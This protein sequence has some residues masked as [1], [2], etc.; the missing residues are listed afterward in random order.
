MDKKNVPQDALRFAIPLLA[1]ESQEGGRK[2]KLRGVAYS[3]EPITGHS[4]WGTVAFDLSST[5]APNRLPVLIEHDRAQRA[6]FAAAEIGGQITIDGE[7]LDN[8]YGRSVAEEADAGF[9]WQLSV[10]IEPGEIAEVKAGATAKVNGHAV[11]GPAFIFRNSLIREVSLTPTG[12]DHRTTAAVFSS[13]AVTTDEDPTEENNV[14]EHEQRIS[15]LESQIQGLQASVTAITGERD[16]AIAERDAAVAE[17]D[18]AT[19]SLATFSA[20]QRTAEV[21]ALFSDLGLEFGDESAAPY[22]AMDAEQFGTVAQHMRAGRGAPP[23]QLFTH[24]ADG[25]GTGAVP[26]DDPKAL[27]AAAVQFQ[28]EQARKG[29]TVDMVKAVR[30]VR[31]VAGG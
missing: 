22:L 3:G 21:K 23:A 28:A 11:H 2:R 12:A 30:H 24:V 5:K 15:D 31:Q 9:P 29:I 10:H 19:A 17:R 13:A 26:T 20:T 16:S 4:Y 14:N 27:A 1:F 8:Q 6:G 18:A 7:L 25:D